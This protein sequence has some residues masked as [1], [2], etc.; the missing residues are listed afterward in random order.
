MK[1]GEMVVLKSWRREKEEKSCMELE[2]K[3][4]CRRE[5][6]DKSSAFFFPRFF[7][8]YLPEFP[9]AEILCAE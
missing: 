4:K 9:L 8:S 1:V 7:L 3:R 5:K 6:A 2:K